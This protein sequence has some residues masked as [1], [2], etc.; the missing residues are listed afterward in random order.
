ML[1]DA[2]LENMSQGLCMYDAEGRVLMLNERY[3]KMTNFRGATLK[4][5]SLLDL[6]K[7]RAASGDF[8]GDPDTYFTEL[9]AKLRQGKS[10]SKIMEVHEGRT[11]RIVDHPMQDGGW[12]ATIEDI[13]DWREAQAKI[14]H[15]ARHDALTDLPNRILF[16]EQLEQALHRTTRDEQVAVLCLD[17]DH[18]KDV[19]ASLGHPVGDEL[20]RAVALRLTECVRTGDTVARLGGDEF[21]IVQVGGLLQPPNAASLAARLVEALSRPYEIQ[22]HQLVIGTSIVMFGAPND[23]YDPDHLLTTAD[24]E[25]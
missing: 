12:V 23:G 25:L 22:N 21:A 15:M 6:L 11:L 13:T 20:L 10:C 19:T 4:G 17:L 8:D 18:F 1:L 3:T 14:T 5:R 7:Q 16:R 24:M 9:T 2:A